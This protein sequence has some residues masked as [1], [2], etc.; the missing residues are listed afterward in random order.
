[1]RLVFLGPPGSGK[2]TGAAL[3][4]KR[5]GVPHLSTGD[6]L[7]EEIR[8]G[9]EL[10]LRVK[11][12]VGGGGLVPDEIVNRMVF[13]R[14]GD[15][16]AGFILDGYPRNVTQARDLDLF[17]GER[18]LTA[19]VHLEVPDEEVERRL[20]G[21]L[22]CEGCGRIFNAGHFPPGTSPEACLECGGRLCH[23]EDDSPEKVRRR[24][25]LYHHETKPLLDYYSGRLVEVDGVGSIEQ[26]AEGIMR[27]LSQ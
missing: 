26:V 4:S 20:A 27:S 18:A 7:R 10:G 19:V 22:V 1:M 6:V 13:D 9:T 23:R 11:G 12:I 14:I 24:L 25:Q 16:E 2:G 5:L 3:V 21:R 15:A 17:L 8:A